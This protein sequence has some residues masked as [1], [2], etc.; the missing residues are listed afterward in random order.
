MHFNFG[1]KEFNVMEG[2]NCHSSPRV[3][4]AKSAAKGEDL[5]KLVGKSYNEKNLL[6]HCKSKY[7]SRNV[8]KSPCL[9]CHELKLL[10]QLLQLLEKI[11]RLLNLLQ[12]LQQLFDFFKQLLKLLQQ[13][14]PP[15][16]SVRRA[17]SSVV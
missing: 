12:Q 3:G 7:V 5:F 15:F 4:G 6:E 16:D 2:L 9:V 10:Q 1:M 13:L 14:T 17:E 8:K 11:K